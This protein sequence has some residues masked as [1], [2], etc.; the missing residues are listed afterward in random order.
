MSNERAPKGTSTYSSWT[1]T[2]NGGM[3]R[4]LG[5][6]IVFTALVTA[7][8]FVLINIPFYFLSKPRETPGQSVNALEQIYGKDHAK[9]YAIVMRE[10]EVGSDYEPFVESIEK[11]RR[12]LFVNVS[13]LGTRCHSRPCE[14][15][16]GGAEEIWVFGGS[17]TF[18]YSVKDDETIPAYLDKLFADKKVVNFGAAS[19]YSTIERIRFQNLLT[20]LPAPHAAVFIDGLNDFYYFETPDSSSF[21]PFI[22]SLVSQER[23]GAAIV[24]QLVRR[25]V[26]GVPIFR[27]FQEGH[28][29]Q[30]RYTATGEEIAAAINRL[31][32]NHRMNLAIG[33][34]YGT[35]V[36]NVVQPVPGYGVGHRNSRVPQEQLNLE[37][38]VNS[39]AAYKAMFDG[40]VLS[41]KY[42]VQGSLILKDLAIEEPMYVDTVHY[43]P[44]FHKKIAEHIH[45][46]LQNRR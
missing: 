37:R 5:L 17:T 15:P 31:V 4:H 45:Q 44:A 21:S 34:L 43:T 22:R 28:R 10:Q 41:S 40:S 3:K 33:Q 12:G 23:S 46:R 24:K 20:R 8:L 1:S 11:S 39:S 16:L 25:I 29:T 36:L 7:V 9:D 6:S 27:F 18:G 35:K 13:S 2:S 32:Q 19:H 42:D 26:S 14:L 38:H 30:T